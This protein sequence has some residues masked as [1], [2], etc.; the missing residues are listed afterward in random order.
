M[1]RGYVLRPE[2]PDRGTLQETSIVF[3]EWEERRN[4]PLEGERLTCR[5]ADR[6]SSRF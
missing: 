6:F 3:V 5:V 2:H 4:G 1:E